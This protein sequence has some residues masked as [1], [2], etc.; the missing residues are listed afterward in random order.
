[1][2]DLNSEILKNPDIDLSAVRL[3]Q[4]RTLARMVI[5]LAASSENDEESQYAQSVIESLPPEGQP[6]PT[7]HERRKKYWE[8]V[9]GQYTAPGASQ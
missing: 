5:E 9:G 3:E 2:S 7:I 1:M 8:S 4:V 6:D